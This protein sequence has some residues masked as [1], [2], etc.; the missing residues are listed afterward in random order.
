MPPNFCLDYETQFP[1]THI[2]ICTGKNR[3]TIFPWFFQCENRKYLAVWWVV[4]NITFPMYKLYLLGSAGSRGY[5]YPTTVYFLASKEV[6]FF[7]WF[8]L[9]YTTIAEHTV[10]T[11]RIFNI[12]ENEKGVV[13]FLQVWGSITIS[14]T[15]GQLNVV[16]FMINTQ[17]LHQFSKCKEQEALNLYWI[18]EKCIK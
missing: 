9:G 14:I 5:P 13:L 7:K 3:E 6:M 4:E 12:E 16:H 18:L 15:P 8:S 11:S 17:S 10:T 2:Y 1:N